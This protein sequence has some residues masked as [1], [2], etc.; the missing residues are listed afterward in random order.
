MLSSIAEITAWKLKRYDLDAA[1]LTT[2]ECTEDNEWFKDGQVVTF[3]AIVGHS[4]TRPDEC[5]GHLLEAWLP[6]IRNEAHNRQPKYKVKP[7]PAAA[8]EGPLC[9]NAD[10]RLEVFVIGGDHALHNIWQDPRSPSAWSAL[11]SLG[12]SFP[13]GPISAIANAD[14]RLEVFL[15]GGD[16]VTYH[17][18][19]SPGSPNGWSG[20]GNLSTRTGSAPAV[21]R[22]FDG[23]LEM[24]GVDDGGHL[25]HTAQVAPNTGWSEPE[26]LGSGLTGSPGVGA[27]SDGRLTVWAV[28]AAGALAGAFQTSAGT[29]WGPLVTLTA[30]VT[31]RPVVARNADG[32]MEVFVLGTDHRI[33]HTWQSGYLMADVVPI[34]DA[35]FSQPPAIG[36]NL[37]GRLELF[38][39]GTDGR[40]WHVYQLAPNSSWSDITVLNGHQF[41]GPPSVITNADGRLEVFVAGAGG[42]PWH[43]WQVAPNSWWS[44]FFPLF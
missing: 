24:L 26:V 40:L 44:D 21:A 16:G 11:S 6:W 4:D 42:V 19:Q 29:A 15:V 8:S 20:Y 35:T 12:G 27:G 2:V 5:P 28:T 33:F 37:D 23:R 14:G 36:R 3:P 34:G 10:G 31:G 25:W 9:R 32:R 39:V 1:G 13:A 43:G 22:N 38:G 18:W 17:A 30:S 41:S 7:P